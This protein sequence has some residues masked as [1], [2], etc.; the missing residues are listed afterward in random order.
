MYGSTG[1][2]EV[3]YSRTITLDPQEFQQV[4]VNLLLNPVQSSRPGQ[5]VLVRCTDWDE[6]GVLIEVVD[7]G[8][9]IAREHLSRVFDPFF[10]TKGARG[11][12]L[13][14]S[15][16]QGIVQGYGGDI[17]VHSSPGQGACFQV[18]LLSNPGSREDADAA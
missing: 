5:D 13:G 2:A 8:T 9:G 16:S 14:L 7:Q 3:P 12:G 18:Y 1:N 4:L 10:T 6:R 17:R 11:T 15:V